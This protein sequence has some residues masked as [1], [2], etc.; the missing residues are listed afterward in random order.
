M[1]DYANHTWGPVGVTNHITGKWEEGK[2]SVTVSI[3]S[4]SFDQVM[5][6]TYSQISREGL[7]FQ[8]SQN[9]GPS[10]PLPGA[11]MSDY[12][13][14][15]STI[16]GKATE[17]SFFDGVD[18]SLGSIAGLA[19]SKPPASLTSGL[20]EIDGLI[21]KAMA[22]F[23]AQKP[24]AIAPYL[25]KGKVKVE[26]LISETDKS[27]LPADAKYNVLHE[28]RIKDRQFNDAL[29]T[30]LQISLNADV[31]PAGK[32]D[33]LMAMFR[34]ALP[35]FQMATPGLAFSVKV[36]LF[37]PEAPSLELKSL[38][39]TGTSGKNWNVADVKAPS[40]I[41][42]GKAIDIVY[43]VR[44]PL[45]E[46]FTR[47]YFTRDGQ[48]NAF[49]EV[50]QDA[51]PN[52]NKPF[53][54]YPLQAEAELTY[55]GASLNLASVV[56]VISKV[57]GPGL[58]RYPMPVG[59]ALS[60]ALS[61]PAGV[62]PLG[63]K[64]TN[65]S[66][67]VHNNTSGAAEPSVSLALPVGWSAEPKSIPIHF[68]QTGEDQTVS[69][70]V[71][72]Q[73]EEGKQYTVTAVA[74]L[75]GKQ[76]KEGY[77]TV[78]YLG[79]RP[80]FLY[81][82]AKYATVGTDVKMA[83]GESIAYVQGSGDDVP[84]ALEQMGVQVAYLSAQDLASGDLQ[85]YDAVVLGVRAYAVRADL[86]ANNARLLQYVEKGGVVIVQYNTPEYDHDYGPYPYVMSGD[87]EEVTDEK[88][89]V[90]IL[91]TNNPVLKWPN[92]ITE[93][94]FDGWV[95]ERGSKFLQS[96]DPKYTALLETHDAGQPDQKGGL[97]YARYGKGVYIYNA[98]AF[99]RQLP[100]GVPGAFRLFANMLSLPK[101]PE[102]H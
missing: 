53:S 79:L 25:A 98:Y 28:L 92:K 26:A 47:P 63:T 22:G 73:V 76:Y 7:G 18:T 34:G 54:P 59:P 84:A 60:V 32:D 42:A 45:D 65:V 13:R 3:P 27:D 35:T 12:H 55:D 1:Y 31:T 41:E 69:F 75:D 44:V 74:S 46:P 52:K 49:Y 2:P 70:A 10:I 99:Y 78:G 102:I 50:A 37:Q 77:V 57:N 11:Q 17:E 19:G 72:P 29:V 101:N 9:G 24:A 4:A 5:G 39:V 93:K 43:S 58:L 66:V 56:Q 33:P 81:S 62:V 68:A 71:I 48:Q 15:G 95:E 8:K 91:D 23:S 86:I 16:E 97:V 14:F 88:S 40:Q 85:K 94:D 6:Q 38:R 90:K 61:P 20:G 82:Q 64:S 51:I 96:W 89:I 87:P 100:L 80:Y 36:H 21:E 30:A 67:R 83:P